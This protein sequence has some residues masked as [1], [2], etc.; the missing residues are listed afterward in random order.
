MRYSAYEIENILTS[1]FSGINFLENINKMERRYFENGIILFYFY[2][3]GAKKVIKFYSL[4]NVPDIQ[5][6]KRIDSLNREYEFAKRVKD[7]PHIVNVY[8]HDK[9]RI[10][11]LLLG[12][13]MFMEFF[14]MTLKDLLVEKRKFPDY[15]IE[16][17][18]R[19]IGSAL[20][21]IHFKISKPIVHCDIKPSNI[22]VREL[23]PGIY[24]FKLMDFDVSMELDEV[25]YHCM[26]S[27]STGFT[28]GYSSPEQVK[29]FVDRQG[30]LT[31]AI[32]IYSLGVIGLQMMTG[33]PPTYSANKFSSELPYRFCNKKWRVIFQKLC[34]LDSNKRPKT[35]NSVFSKASYFCVNLVLKIL[36]TLLAVIIIIGM[37]S[38]LRDI[39]I[40]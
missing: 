37:I 32:D 9:I 30:I 4:Q 21:T 10:N 11:G 38:Y 36:V 20:E 34:N 12:L 5:I 31:N 22:G 7:H 6:K 14:P 13:V 1:N 2:E 35:I 8:R 23:E 28:P 39:N 25:S 18:F 17:F 3:N 16:S 27:S 15:T 33:I 19:Q 26:S 40:I 24:K 29:A